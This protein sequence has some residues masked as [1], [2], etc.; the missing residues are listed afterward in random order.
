VKKLS[1]LVVAIALLAPA[2]VR[3]ADPNK[4]KDAKIAVDK[5][6]LPDF[7]I[8]DNKSGTAPA[9]GS[10]PAAM[11]P[12]KPKPAKKEL[13]VSKMLFGPEAVRA[14][15]NF[16]MPDI[17][18]CYEKVVADTGKNVEGKVFVGFIIDANGNVSDARVLQKKSTLKDDRIQ[19]CVLT[20]RTWQF[21]KPDDNRDHP[22]EYPFNLTLQK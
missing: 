11:D 10:G 19:E 5:P 15:V 4:D 14:V 17:L 3:A 6:V 12:N 8:D 1:T 7:K 18:E 16:H 21:P 13:D 9:A 22:I 2:A 20:M